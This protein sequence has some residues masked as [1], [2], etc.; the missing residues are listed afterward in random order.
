MALLVWRDGSHYDHFHDLPCILCRK[1]TPLRSHADEAVHKVCAELW[2]PRNPGSR[3]FHSD[4]TPARQSPRRDQ[5]KSGPVA[6]AGEPGAGEALFHP[7]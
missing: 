5:P 6:A 7:G 3:C 2:T 1:P 4:H